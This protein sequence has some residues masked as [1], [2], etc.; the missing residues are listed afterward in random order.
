MCSS[1]VH[2]KS[3]WNLSEWSPTLAHSSWGDGGK[4]KAPLELVRGWEKT[5][6]H[7]HARVRI[8][9][10]WCS[11]RG[12]NSQWMDAVNSE[13]TLLSNSTPIFTYLLAAMAAMTGPLTLREPPRLDDVPSS[14][15]V[16]ILRA[17]GL[18]WWFW[19]E[20]ACSRVVG[21]IQGANCSNAFTLLPRECVCL[22][23]KRSVT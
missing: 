10:C 15:S 18:V 2:R 5:R 4:S 11:H 13:A 23:A 14:S 12:S 20:L 19:R 8:P 1:L 21:C 9:F 22:K 16:K 17:P 3:R 6:T 7:T